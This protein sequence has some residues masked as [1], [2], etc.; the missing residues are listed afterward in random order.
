MKVSNF[1]VLLTAI[2]F[3]AAAG[4]ADTST[5]VSEDWLFQAGGEPSLGLAMKEIEWAR[6]IAARIGDGADLEAE[7]NELRKL[8]Q[9][10]EDS[11]KIPRPEREFY[12]A[13]REVKRSI[14]F[15]DPLIDFNEILLIDNPYPI[16]GQEPGHEARHRNGFMAIMGGRLAV[17]EGLDPDAN[18][19]RLAPSGSNEAS[20]WR[21]DLSWDA[22]KVIY[23]MRPEGE[24]SF[25]I[26]ECNIDGS[27]VKQLTFGDYDDLDPIYTPDGKIIF[28]TTRGHTYVRCMPYTHS[29]VLARC[30]A[31]GSNIYVISRNSE[32]D[33]LPSVLNDGRIIYTRWEYTDKALWR[34]QSLW[35]M[36]ADG[37][38]VIHF[39]G[40]QSV[41]P[42]VITEAR[43]IPGSRKV[44]FTGVGHHSW[45]EGC[46]GII[47]PDRGLN[48]PDGLS[49][50]TQELKWPEVNDGPGDP[51]L[52]VEYHASGK[53]GAYKTPYPLSEEVFLV[54]VNAGPRI[55]NPTSKSELFSL[56][57]MDVYGNKELIWK[58]RHNAYHAVPVRART[59]PQLVPDM[60]A[61]PGTG[62]DHKPVEDGVLYTNNVFEGAPEINRD[63]V[64]Y[65]RIIE[66]DPKTYSTWWKTVQHDG[67]AVGLP[68]AESVK[69]VYG[70][71]PVEK[72]GSVCFKLKP[73]VGY[74]FQLIDKDYRVI[75]NMRSF[76]GVMPGET[77]G[78]MGCHELRNPAAGANVSNQRRIGI[79]M[80]KG[81]V[82]PTP[83]PWGRESV[84]F[85]RFA[86]PVFDKY[87]IKCH[88]GTKEKPKLNLT[89]RDSKVPWRWDMGSHRPGEKTPFKEPYVELIGGQIGWGRDVPKNK[90]GIAI[91]LSG[92]FI[93]E[94]YGNQQ[95]PAAQNLKT[96][97]P[98]AAFSHKSKIVE[99]AM[100]GKHHN[101]KVDPASLRR[102]IAWVDCNGPYLGEE[103]IREMYDANFVT[104][105]IGAIPAR[106][107]TAPEIDRFNIR[108]DGDSLAIVGKAVYGGE[109]TTS[110]HG[111]LN[112]GINQPSI[113]L[114]K[115]AEIIKVTYGAGKEHIDVTDKTRK[116][117]AYNPK[118]I[119]SFNRHFGD[120]AQGTVKVLIITY[121]LK[122]KTQLLEVP[123]NSQLVIK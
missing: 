2:I 81:A 109:T 39:W 53:Y 100:S 106:V 30:D 18:V 1:V 49:K 23:S 102:L 55:H 86:Q 32:P 15:K 58:G 92:C 95:D 90:D 110:T 48:Y 25:H 59:K 99:N 104:N 3:F 40:N 112:A 16:A 12:F 119:S 101:V 118:Q 113:E 93:V 17:I 10:L 51:D 105:D 27:G 75:Q 21:P 73:G 56:Y 42:D 5:A 65:M 123:E 84:G 79:A 71:V 97:P 85:L 6:Q 7:L 77:R 72:D 45:F 22:K 64:K 34:V 96:F 116:I 76:T 50:V 60:V 29:F 14:M 88:N 108:Q 26:Y 74:Y 63:E 111:S 67:P 117:M 36:N 87:C 38:N 107:R 80:K 20:F 62:K 114:P 82:T 57:L 103:E 54:S 44:M 11:T 13:V 41:W 98:K 70:T 4:L 43:A 115:G 52:D 35:T 33:Y 122:G 9:E 24:K 68:Q 78:C 69:R 47:D 66:M 19:R 31:D 46:I 91:S 83:P 61:W 89:L 94:G 120:P 37:T 121:K 8:S 28:C